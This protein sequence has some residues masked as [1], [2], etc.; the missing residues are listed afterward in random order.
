MAVFRKCI[1]IRERWAFPHAVAAISKL[2]DRTK[3]VVPV[4]DSPPEPT[5]TAIE[6][7]NSRVTPLAEPWGAVGDFRNS[8]QS[9]CPNWSDGLEKQLATEARDVLKFDVHVRLVASIERSGRGKHR[10]FVRVQPEN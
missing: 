4:V 10:D 7:N 8:M 2:F 3:V 9:S 1:G 5:G 6:G